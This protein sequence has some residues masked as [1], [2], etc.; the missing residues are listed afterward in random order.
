MEASQEELRTVCPA[1]GAEVDPKAPETIRAF[2][3]HDLPG[4][5]QAHDYVDGMRAAFHPGCYPKGSP[6]YRRAD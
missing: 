4:F 3:V 2:E 1:C 5:G 6:R